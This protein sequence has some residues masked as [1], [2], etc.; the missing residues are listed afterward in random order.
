MRNGLNNRWLEP[1]VWY[2]PCISEAMDDLHCI[3]PKFISSPLVWSVS[4]LAVFGGGLCTFTP[5]NEFCSFVSQKKKFI[6][7]GIHIHRHESHTLGIACPLE[8]RFCPSRRSE[9]Q[10]CARAAI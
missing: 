5:C 9:L 7:S 2:A 1:L 4:L 8:G 6:S 10:I 3:K